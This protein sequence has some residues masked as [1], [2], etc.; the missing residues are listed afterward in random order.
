MKSYDT[1]GGLRER[2]RENE[3][4]SRGERKR[5]YDLRDAKRENGE[6]WEER[7]IGLRRK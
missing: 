5:S 4:G 2:E 3:K 7:E 1:W 6:Y